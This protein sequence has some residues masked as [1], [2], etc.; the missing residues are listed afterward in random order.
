M[1][2]KFRPKFTELDVDKLKRP[3]NDEGD[4]VLGLSSQKELSTMSFGECSFGNGKK[5]LLTLK[6]EM[7]TVA[8]NGHNYIEDS[9]EGIGICSQAGLSSF[10]AGQSSGGSLN[11]IELS[12]EKKLEDEN[13]QV[14]IK[15]RRLRAKAIKIEMD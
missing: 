10:S 2:P 7:K 12:V 3:V 8:D 11:D 4:D 14:A 15:K 5:D 6:E 9:E 1:K 13:D